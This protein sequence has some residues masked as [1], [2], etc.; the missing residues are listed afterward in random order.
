MRG[1]KN[2]WLGFPAPDCRGKALSDGMFL[3]D[4]LFQPANAACRATAFE[5]AVPET[6]QRTICCI[7]NVQPLA[8][9]SVQ[10]DAF[11]DSANLQQP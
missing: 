8:G 2:T 9:L 7:R 5:R 11:V 10:P 4:S 3:S 1:P 6:Q